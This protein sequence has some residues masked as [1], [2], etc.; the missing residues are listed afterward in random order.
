MEGFRYNLH[1]DQRGIIPR[2]AEDIFD[3]IRDFK[4]SDITYMV[5]VS[6][7]QIYNEVLTDLL[8]Q[9]KEKLMI[10]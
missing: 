9:E 7:I 8:R 3:Y 6:Y 5:R 2:A 1:D 4:N 10:R